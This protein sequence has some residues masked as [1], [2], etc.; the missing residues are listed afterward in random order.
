MEVAQ[1]ERKEKIHN[2][3]YSRLKETKKIM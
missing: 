1:K 3:F 2:W